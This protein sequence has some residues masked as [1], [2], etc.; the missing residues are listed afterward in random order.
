MDGLGTVRAIGAAVRLRHMAAMEWPAIGARIFLELA[1]GS[2]VRGGGVF[3][4]GVLADLR[5]VEVRAR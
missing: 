5:R 3:V 2:D 4:G 1:A